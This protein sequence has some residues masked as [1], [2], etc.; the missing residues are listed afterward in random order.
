MQHL[1]I[2][3]LSTLFRKRALH[4]FFSFSERA[5]RAH[6]E[7]KRQWSKRFLAVKVSEQRA[8]YITLLN[9]IE[10]YYAQNANGDWNKFQINLKNC[11]MFAEIF[12]VEKY[13][14][15]NVNRLSLNAKRKLL[16]KIF[17]IKRKK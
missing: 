8:N 6:V 9:E 14:S 11:K 17:S 12:L 15:L 13:K 2:F 5:C 1:I 10:N 3:H 7:L 4:I 16:T